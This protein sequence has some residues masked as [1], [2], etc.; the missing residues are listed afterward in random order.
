MVLNGG[1]V[2]EVVIRRWSARSV[3]SSNSQGEVEGKEVI[4][5]ADL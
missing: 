1:E 2:F 3:E 4:G 5:G